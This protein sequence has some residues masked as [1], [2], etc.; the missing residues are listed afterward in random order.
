VLSNGKLPVT[1]EMDEEEECASSETLTKGYENRIK[2]T[3]ARCK[4]NSRYLGSR[5][6]RGRY[7][8]KKDQLAGQS[9]LNQELESINFENLHH[10]S[11]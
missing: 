10:C 1:P 11:P 5:L 2:D 8:M 9:K 7:L 6:V 3:E 4:D